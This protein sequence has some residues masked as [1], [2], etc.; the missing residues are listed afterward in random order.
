MEKE[1][2]LYV[3]NLNFN[4]SEDE[5]RSYFEQNGIQPKSVTLIKDKYTGRAKGF[6]FVEVD[7]AEA[8]QKA[9]EALDGKELG[10]RAL[11]VNE[12]KPP[13]EKNGGGGFGQRRGPRF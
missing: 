12:A 6:G 5:L 2:K 10:G 9:I 11:R 1:N 7:S 4:T 8:M 3:G 13:R